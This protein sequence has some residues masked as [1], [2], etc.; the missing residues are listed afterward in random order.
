LSLRPFR[1][2]FLADMQLGAYASFSGLTESDVERYAVELGMKVRAVP[3]TTGFEWDSARYSEAVAA[4]NSMRPD[5]VLIGGDMI[6]DPHSVAQHDEFMR[7]TGEIDRDIPVR[8]VP[9]NHDIAPDTVV[10]TPESLEE[11]RSAY[12]DDYYGFDLGPVRFIALN[13]VVI[14]HPEKVPGEWEAQLAFVDDQLT[15]AAAS[16]QTPVLVGHHP[17]FTARPDEPDDYWNLPIERRRLLLDRVHRHGVP[18][19]L[20]GHRHRNSI[21]HDGGFEMIATS[22][23]GYPL[24]DDPSGFRVFEVGESG[25]RHDYVAL[26]D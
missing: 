24:G 15:G 9:G 7:L 20:A 19:G 26:G 4:V 5:L 11:Y 10:P 16:G 2:A 13:T 6:D 23:V 12:G 21:S 17:L 1:F 8:W 25:I 18:M 3:A 14:D 22:A